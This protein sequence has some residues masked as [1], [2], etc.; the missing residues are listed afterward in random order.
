M[1]CLAI[2]YQWRYHW[3]VLVGE[4]DAE[5]MLLDYRVIRPAARPVEFGNNGPI[6]LD[7]DLVDAILIAVQCQKATIAAKPEVLE[8]SKN[9]VGL[10]PDIRQCGIVRPGHFGFSIALAIAGRGRIIVLIVTIRYAREFNC[11]ELLIIL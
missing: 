9:V 6:V 8:R 11:S 2:D 3:N 7:A 1:Q 4:F 5:F 10:Q